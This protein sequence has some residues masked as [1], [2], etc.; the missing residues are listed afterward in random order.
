MDILKGVSSAIAAKLPLPVRSQFQKR[1]K[2]DADTIDLR[3]IAQVQELRLLA[4]GSYNSVWLV[5]LYE[6]LEITQPT[7]AN[8]LSVNQFILRFPFEDALLPDQITNEVAFKRFV[9][10]KLPHIPVPQVYLYNATS[11]PDTSYIVEEYIDCPPL[12]STWMSLT[13]SQKGKVAQKLAT[14]LVDLTEI[15]F[16]LIGGL[17]PTDLSSAPTVEGCKIFKGR[18][19]F[20]RNECY[21][22]GPYQTTKEY[23]LSCYD[24]EIYY[25]NHATEDIDADLFGDVPVQAFVENLKRERRSF[26][27]ADIVDEPFVLVHGDFHGRN[28]LARGDQ[29]TAVL[30][31]EFAGSYPL[32]E[33]LA[34]SDFHVV[35]ATNKELGEENTVWGNKIRHFIQH[36]V[37]KRGWD[38][39]RI[40]LLMG[41]GG[42]DL[43]QA[44]VE[45]LPWSCY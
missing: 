2:D 43:A 15:Q 13:P 39:S 25:Y 37:T 27:E 33:T 23:I 11:Q 18:G 40:G 8:S 6:S 20:H 35:E 29:I 31:W 45:M 44:R 4:T 34:G 21:P 36:E 26:V 22:I 17:N 42:M 14:I 30:D 12:N 5:E 28:I 10:T 41:G 19:K 3:D 24:R 1:N 38:R 7:D 32:S 16:D 9:A